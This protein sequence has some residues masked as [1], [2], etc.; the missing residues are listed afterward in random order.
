MKDEKGGRQRRRAEIKGKRK[1]SKE[2]KGE[3]QK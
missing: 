1:K 2:D 3:E